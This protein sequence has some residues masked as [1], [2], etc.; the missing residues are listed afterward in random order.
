MGLQLFMY[1]KGC[2]KKNGNQ[3]FTRVDSDRTK[4]NGFKLREGRFRIGCQGEVLY[5]E[6][7]EVLEQASQRSCGYSVPGD[8]QGQ[9][10][11][12]PGQPGLLP[13]LEVGGPVYDRGVG[14]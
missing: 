2:C 13:D 10:G 3:L 8:V 6:S 9:V 4:G 5:R 11:W 7:C 14:T 12:G 1:L